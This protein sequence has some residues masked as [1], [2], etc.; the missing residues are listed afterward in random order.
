MTPPTS[1][2]ASE[3][4][5]TWRSRGLPDHLHGRSFLDVGCWEGDLSAEAVNWGAM[6]IVGI[7]Y[8]TSPDLVQT[9]AITAFTFIQVD[10]LSEKALELPGFDVVHCAGV[11]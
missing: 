1:A 5:A 3:L 4:A 2:R 6:P 8:C 9:L 10:I 11:L 7:N